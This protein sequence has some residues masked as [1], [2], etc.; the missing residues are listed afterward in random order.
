MNK[1]DIIK[2]LK[3]LHTCPIKGWYDLD[4][5]ASQ[6]DVWKAQAEWIE[7][8][9]NKDYITEKELA[10]Q[11]IINKESV[12]FEYTINILS[13]FSNRGYEIDIN[14]VYSHHIKGHRREINIDVYTN[15]I[16]VDGQYITNELRDIIFDLIDKDMI[17]FK[18]KL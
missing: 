6:N 17:I 5:N 12:K 4:E 13:Y 8:Q 10:K 3:L 18:E 15:K 14:P 11:A 9:L 16:Y 2:V 1:D 7:E